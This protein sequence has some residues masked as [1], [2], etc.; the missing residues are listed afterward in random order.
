MAD[1]AEVLEAYDYAETIDVTLS[2]GLKVTLAEAHV[3]RNADWGLA[4]WVMMKKHKVED[5]R[6][7]PEEDMIKVFCSTLLKAWDA[8]KDGEPIEPKDAA[9]YLTDSR[10]GRILYREMVTICNVSS[11]FLGGEA[12]KKPS[13]TSTLNGTSSA[14]KRK[15]SRSKPKPE[16]SP[17]LPA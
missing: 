15:T 1:I 9:G 6:L 2:G 4:I 17:S 16:N 10:A 3:T 13:S 8:T 11:R 5:F 14:T 12:K 7:I